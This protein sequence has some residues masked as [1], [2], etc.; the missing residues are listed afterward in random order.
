M[1]PQS[2]CVVHCFWHSCKLCRCP[3]IVL[4]RAYCTTWICA[5]VKGVTACAAALQMCTATAS[6]CGRSAHGATR[7]CTCRHAATWW[8]IPSCHHGHRIHVGCNEA[9]ISYRGH[10]VRGQ[11]RDVRVP[12]ECPAAVEQLIAACI[13]SDVAAR[14][15]SQEVVARLVQIIEDGGGSASGGGDARCTSSSTEFGCCRR[16]WRACAVLGFGIDGSLVI[17]SAADKSPAHLEH[18]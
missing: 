3:V 10:P 8:Q 14:P 17:M 18:A 7:A 5:L 6:C 2:W 13:N 12:A 4:Q 15:S 11:L 16:T 1:L 9:S